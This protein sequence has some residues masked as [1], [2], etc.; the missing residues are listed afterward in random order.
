[1]VSPTNL[2]AKGPKNQGHSNTGKKKMKKK[3]LLSEVMSRDRQ[4]SDDFDAPPACPAPRSGGS[5][6]VGELLFSSSAYSREQRLYYLLAVTISSVGASCAQEGG[7]HT[8]VFVETTAVAQDLIVKLKALSLTAFAVH[9][10]TIKAQVCTTGNACIIIA[11]FGKCFAPL[12][13]YS[14]FVLSC[15]ELVRVHRVLPYNRQ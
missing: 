5:E 11:V 8:V 4:D 6:A 15:I 13:Y 10:R 12:V 2:L 1:M 3:D 14:Y 9:E 7:C